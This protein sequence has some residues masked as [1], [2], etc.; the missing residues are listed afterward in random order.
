MSVGLYYDA[1]V[2]WHMP[3]LE[4]ICRAEQK[5]MPFIGISGKIQNTGT[6]TK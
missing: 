4:G 3:I 5:Y 6:Y 1:N 2:K